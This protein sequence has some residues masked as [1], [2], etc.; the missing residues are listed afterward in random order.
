PE[1]THDFM[2]YCPDVWISDYTYQAI[3]NVLATVPQAAALDT[4]LESNTAGILVSGSYAKNGSA[5]EL[6][7]AFVLSNT[8]SLQL[9]G[10]G[11]FRLALVNSENIEVYI[12]AFDPEEVTEESLNDGFSQFTFLLPDLDD[13]QAVRFYYQN[14]LLDEFTTTA[15]QPVVT[16]QTE[17]PALVT[18]ESLTLSWSSTVTNSQYMVRFSPDNGQTWQTLTPPRSATTFT[19]DVQTLQGTT[20]GL[21]EIVASNGLVSGSARTAVFQVASKAPEVVILKPQNGRQYIEEGEVVILMGSAYDLEDGN[22]TDEQFTWISD[23]DGVIGHGRVLATQNLSTGQHTIT[24]QVTDTDN[25]I[26]ETTTSIQ[27]GVSLYLPFI[28]R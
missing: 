22:L 26:G 1:S 14:I 13:I 25:Q 27:I 2:S 19:V 18:G 3:Y 20:A 4:Q 6:H 23:R 16:I 9:N 17:V 5:G 8:Q 7:S 12:Q 21:F 10:G 24:L 28:I 11:D 15:E